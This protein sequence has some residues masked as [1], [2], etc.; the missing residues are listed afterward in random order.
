M[1]YCC[2]RSSVRLVSLAH[3]ADTAEQL[4]SDSQGLNM[5]AAVT[6]AQTVGGALAPS[7]KGNTPVL[8]L[9]MD[10][11]PYRSLAAARPW[12]PGF[13]LQPP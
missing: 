5:L 8:E 1:H 2:T 11:R 4:R 12:P 10:E 13:Y 9:S 7:S 6:A 3:Q